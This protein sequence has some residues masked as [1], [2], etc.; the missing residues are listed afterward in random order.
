MKKTNVH[1]Y[2]SVILTYIRKTFIDVLA[3][4]AIF[5]SALSLMYLNGFK[6]NVSIAAAVIAVLLYF[7]IARAKWRKVPFFQVIVFIIGAVVICRFI[8]FKIPNIIEP[9]TFQYLLLFG[10][11]ISVL[12]SVNPYLKSNFYGWKINK[13]KF[14]LFV[15]LILVAIMLYVIY[16]LIS[17]S[18]VDI[19]KMTQSKLT[20]AD[21]NF[22]TVAI[23]ESDTL[24]VIEKQ[25]IINKIIYN[26]STN[27]YVLFITFLS[28]MSAGI[29]LTRWHSKI[30]SKSPTT[31]KNKESN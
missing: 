13:N 18:S 27:D 26:N 11:L 30:L 23:N 3:C 6:E 4:S 22:I 29:I 24:N 31:S 9:S 16:A 20:E 10:L 8:Y 19:Y 12:D 21:I 17:I 28:L 2:L 15:L 5:L 14:S 25:N 7:L 1:N